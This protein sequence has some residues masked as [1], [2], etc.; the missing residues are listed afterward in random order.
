[1]TIQDQLMIVSENI[2]KAADKA[3]RQLSDIRLL[4][5]TKTV[6]A[7]IIN[8]AIESGVTLI[9]ENR[10]QELLEKEQAL[11]P[12]E[13]HFIGSLQSNK[14]HQVFDL[15]KMIHSVDRISLAKRINEIAEQRQKKMPILI[16][17]N[18]G[19]ED[20]KGGVNPDEFFPFIEQLQPLLFL[21]VCGLMC[22]PPK[23]EMDEARPYFAQTYELA[24]K[25]KMKKIDEMSFD[26]LSMGMSHDYQAAIAE[27]STILRLG[28]CI[29]G[30]R[31]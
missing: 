6:P 19:R 25:A 26:Q 30:A 20:S 21:K 18:I 24:Q 5:V 9:G 28:S 15:V 27:G 12:V 3:H 4:A 29:F 8:Q 31:N 10:A 17:V 16:E 11:L 23:C 14:V 1:M 7:N 2:S 13:K 22:I